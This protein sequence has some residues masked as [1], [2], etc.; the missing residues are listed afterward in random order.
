M[1]RKHTAGVHTGLS[2][3]IAATSKTS[4]GKGLV[5]Q[6]ARPSLHNHFGTQASQVPKLAGAREQ[7]MPKVQP[8]KTTP[9]SHAGNSLHAK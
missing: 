7:P 1:I 2:T 5:A 3:T 9:A 8:K 4:F 6:K